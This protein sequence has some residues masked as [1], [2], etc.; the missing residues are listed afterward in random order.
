MILLV[1]LI[2][3]RHMLLKNIYIYIYSTGL[4][5]IFLVLFCFRIM[6]S[7]TEEDGARRTE[8][9]KIQVVVLDMS[10]KS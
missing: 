5:I 3:S 10:S 9:S 8:K 7:V 2:E 4:Y 6:R 1:N